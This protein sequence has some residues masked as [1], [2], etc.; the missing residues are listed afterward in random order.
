[1]D[2]IVNFT[3]MGG[4]FPVQHNIK[5]ENLFHQ[6][7]KG[8]MERKHSCE[9]KVNIIR[10]E[11]LLT[12]LEKIIEYHT[13]NPIDV[14]VFH[15]RP[16]PFLR[17]SKLYYK[18]VNESGTLCRSLN[19]PFFKLINPE[20]YDYLVLGRRFIINP[21]I[22]ESKLHKVLIDLNLILGGLA[23]NHY[24]TLKAYVNLLK[25]I[26]SY[27]EDKKV[28][29]IL[30]GP[31]LRPH[32]RIENLLSAKLNKYVLKSLERTNITYV[33]GLGEVSEFNMPLFF[34]NGIHVNESYH[35]LIANRLI[36]EFG[37]L[38]NNNEI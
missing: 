22:K 18:Y 8:E 35:K 7:I 15:I 14:L 38:I 1:M 29:L 9:L 25:Q 26:I 5:H 13:E 34:E 24:L 10:Y 23:T 27:C 6:L 32:T 20:K 12:C 31:A 16:E 4:C 33:S 2:K 36:D 17:L 21:K 19:L 28:K 11:R 3:F 30:L 37:N